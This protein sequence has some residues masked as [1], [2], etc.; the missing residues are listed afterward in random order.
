[1][2][3]WSKMLGMNETPVEPVFD[4][5]EATARDRT[6]AEFHRDRFARAIAQCD[7]GEVR[8]AE[9]KRW[10]EYYAGLAAAEAA[11]PTA[12]EGAS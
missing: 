1:M 10:H 3:F 2:S 7:K 4:V 5:G 12:E 6:Q 9:L 11:M 8:L